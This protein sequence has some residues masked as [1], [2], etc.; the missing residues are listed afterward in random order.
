MRTG[1]FHANIDACSSIVYVRLDAI[2][3]EAR[4]NAGELVGLDFVQT[5]AVYAA[6]SSQLR[7]VGAL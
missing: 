1:F 3:H 6:L 4:G 2:E 5:A 7:R